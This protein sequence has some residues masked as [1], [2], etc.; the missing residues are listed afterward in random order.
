M[1]TNAQ[2]QA[3]YRSRQRD[4]VNELFSLHDLP[5]LPAVSTIPGWARWKEAMTRIGAQMEVIE[6]EMSAY[7][8]ERSERW[9]ESD[10]AQVF[11]ERLEI[12]GQLIESV[13]CWPE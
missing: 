11:S 8:D 6:S 4:M 2:R 7:Y 5:S 13:Q 3:A 1:A 12:L 9:Q 10:Q